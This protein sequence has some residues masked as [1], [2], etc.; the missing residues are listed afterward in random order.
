MVAGR[1]CRG[2]FECGFEEDLIF[3][4]ERVV[5]A[6]GKPKKRSQN[7]SDLLHGLLNRSRLPWRERLEFKAAFAE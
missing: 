5:E 4:R 2:V 3:P 6:V 1:H 7:S